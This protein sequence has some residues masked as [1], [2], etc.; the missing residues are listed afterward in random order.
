MAKD[1]RATLRALADELAADGDLSDE[2]IGR[3]AAAAAVT[4]ERVLA[5]RSALEQAHVH[6][7]SH[8]TTEKADDAICHDCRRPLV[9]DVGTERI[10]VCPTLHGLRPAG[11]RPSTKHGAV[12]CGQAES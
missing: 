5:E 4:A 9:S 12:E 3:I 6:P 7:T 2:D 11:L 10:L 1:A 8:R